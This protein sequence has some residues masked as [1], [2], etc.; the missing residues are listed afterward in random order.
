YFDVNQ[1]G[2]LRVSSAKAFLKPIRSRAN[3]TVWT[4]AQA[5]RLLFSTDLRG[6]RHCEGVQLR[7]EGARV[8]VRARREVILSAGAIGS[9]QLLQLSG[10]GPAA[11]LREHGIEVVADLPGVG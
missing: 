1:R 7:H 5:E 8:T 4:R 2:G 11:L 6:R 9:P 3:L 10:L